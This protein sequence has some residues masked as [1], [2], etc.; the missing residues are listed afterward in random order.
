MNKDKR[1]RIVIGHYGSGKT[2]FS[3]NYVTKLARMDKKTVLVDLDVVNLYFRSREKAEE[4][5]NMGIKVIGGSVKANAIDIPMIP[6]EVLTAFQ[7]ESF[8]AVLDVGGDPAGARTLGRYVEYLKEGNYDM[9]F[10]LNA[11]RPETQTVEKA[12]E[13]L[14]RIEDTVRAK[15]TGIVNNT[16]MLK[17]TSINDVLKGYELSLKLSEETGVP[18]RYNVVLEDLVSDLP[19]DLKGEVFPIDLIMREEW[20]L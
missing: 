3:L 16:H 18:L 10:V 15:V 20:M 17:S 11:N 7:D 6:G 12:M 5:E 9:F 2:E 14:T 4:L 13:Y 1:V 8:D 19:K